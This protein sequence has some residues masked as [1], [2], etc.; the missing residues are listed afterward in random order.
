MHSLQKA[1]LAYKA[2]K[3]EYD[4]ATDAVQKMETG[5]MMPGD[6]KAD[7]KKKLKAEAQQK[8]SLRW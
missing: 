2:R 4:K 5:G 3:I 7:R 1:N 8:V 6:G